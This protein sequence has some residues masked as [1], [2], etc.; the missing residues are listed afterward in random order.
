MKDWP[1][2]SS[3][4]IIREVGNVDI[5]VLLKF[6]NKLETVVGHI[7]FYSLQY[8]KCKSALKFI[9]LLLLFN[10]FPF[11]VVQKCPHC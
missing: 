10:L 7:N 4:P 11:E 5:F 1:S 9:H 6:E 2:H 8:D 3:F